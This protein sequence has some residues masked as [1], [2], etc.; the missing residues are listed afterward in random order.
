MHIKSSVKEV[1]NIYLRAEEEF[2]RLLS[3]FRF[4][5]YNRPHHYRLRQAF[6]P[7]NNS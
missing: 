2:Q 4:A 1:M 6:P 5:L 7:P 3:V